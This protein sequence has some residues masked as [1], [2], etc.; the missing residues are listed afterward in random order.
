MFCFVLY[1]YKLLEKANVRIL[2]VRQEINKM[3]SP[4]HFKC[5]WDRE[6]LAEYILSRFS[7]IAKPSTVSDDLGTDLFCTL[8]R[9][10][11]KKGIDYPLPLSSF[12]IQIKSNAQ[13]F[14]FSAN[15]TYLQNLEIPFFLGVVSESTKELSIFSGENLPKFFTH[16]GP[17][18]KLKI[19]PLER[20]SMI[21]PYDPMEGCKKDYTVMF[22]KL[23]NIGIDSTKEDLE[24]NVEVLRD[25]CSLIHRN[26]ATAKIQEYIFEEYDKSS[27]SILAGPGSVKTFRSN[28]VKRLAENFYNL[29]WQYKQ[30]S[31]CNIR[32]KEELIKEFKI[33]EETYLKIQ[34]LYRIDEILISQYKK[35]KSSLFR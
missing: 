10:E 4:H 35:S 19:E 26:I 33:Y 7:F 27:Y 30:Y 14:D 29:E 8:F 13:P 2:I 23:I 17:L 18:S 5:G 34:K 31:Q 32:E 9:L 16:I 12:A 6:R 3:A 28:F 20:R 15:I 21:V 25:L 24:E 1:C 22:P 11:E